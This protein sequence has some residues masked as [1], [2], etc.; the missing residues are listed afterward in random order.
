[1]NWMPVKVYS[2]SSFTPDLPLRST[3][4]QQ[5][6]HEVQVKAAVP[7]DLSRMKHLLRESHEVIKAAALLEYVAHGT[8][9]DITGNGITIDLQGDELTGQPHEG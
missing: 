4:T 5:S 1:M 6:Y 2:A 7:I 8:R 3:V 9:Y